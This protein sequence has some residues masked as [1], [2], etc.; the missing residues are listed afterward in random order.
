MAILYCLQ[1]NSIRVGTYH[2]PHKHKNN[3]NAVLLE[4]TFQYVTVN[5]AP[6]YEG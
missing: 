6:L 2:M 3:K 4:K 1:L 5:R